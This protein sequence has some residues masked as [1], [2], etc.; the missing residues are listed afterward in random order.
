M[1]STSTRKIEGFVSLG[2]EAPFIDPNDVVIVGLDE[3]ET[4]DNWYAHCSRLADE[5]DA[6]LAEYVNDIRLSGKV[7]EPI[8]VV[9][10]G[11]RV[12]VLDGRR[13][14]R[15]A[16]MVWAEQAKAGVP[17]AERVTVRVLIRRGTAEDLFR[18]NV[19]S[20]KKKPLTPMQRARM[21]LKHFSCTGE[22]M[23]KTAEAFGVTTQTIK[24]MSSLID[25]APDVQRAVD[26]GEL[27]IR[28]AIKLADRPRD[29]QKEILA[30]LTANDAL[31]GARASNG[32]AAAKKGKRVQNDTRKMRSR[33]F[34]EKWR[35]T[36]KKDERFCAVKV[37][38]DDVLKFILGGGVPTDFPE[39][40]KESLVEA[41]FKQRKAAA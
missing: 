33:T 3:P 26:K 35:D 19:D 4:A 32:I 22:D 31:S 28:E 16:R 23:K 20:H 37:P 12:V 13:S 2:G 11:D 25:L 1:G 5:T 17:V 10:D 38:L 27:P 15:A 39:R 24:N 36:V 21:I 30:Q 14:T 29:E 7:D 9:R 8:D 34:L 41:G 18:F 6:D 40:V